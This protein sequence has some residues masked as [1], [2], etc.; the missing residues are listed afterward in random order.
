M[1]LH[2]APA[3][4]VEWGTP[5]GLFAQLHARFQ[6]EIDVCAMPHNAKL[7]RYFSP[8][9]DGL[10]QRWAPMRCFLNP[11]YGAALRLWMA[12]ARAE[13]KAGALV[14]SLVPAR[15]DTAVWH[16]LIAPLEGH[17]RRL[18]LGYGVSTLGQVMLIESEGLVTEITFLRGRV[19]FVRPD[20]ALAGAPTYPSAVVVFAPPGTVLP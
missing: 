18:G 15:T 19:R 7:P 9:D 17:V 3:A 20:G 10:A 1:G 11:P 6:F 12:K 13:A 8:T 16:D 2:E 4:T 14:C 5:P